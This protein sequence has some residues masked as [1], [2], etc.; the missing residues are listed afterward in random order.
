MLLKSILSLHMKK[1]GSFNLQIE[2]FLLGLVLFFVYLFDLNYFFKSTSNKSKN[3][4]TKNK[5][6]MR[7]NK[8]N[9]NLQFLTLINFLI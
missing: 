6:K 1:K 4:Y 3:F 7:K 2:F 5:I 9:I 8:H